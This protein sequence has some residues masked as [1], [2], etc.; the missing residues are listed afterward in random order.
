MRFPCEI[1]QVTFHV[2][3]TCT[4]SHVTFNMWNFTCD[5]SHVNF[6]IWNITWEIS[7]GKF[8]SYM[9][10]TCDISHNMWKV[11]YDL[12]VQF[13]VTYLMWKLTCENFR[14]E[15]SQE[16]FLMVEEVICGISHVNL[17]V[18]L[19]SCEILFFSLSSCSVVACQTFSKITLFWAITERSQHGIVA[20]LKVARNFILDHADTGDI[21]NSP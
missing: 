18:R 1:L 11:L 8:I 3:F 19:F 9:K 20:I 21:D 4:I 16:E 13:C 5:F 14:C 17:S 6:L 15:F 7:H 10:V 2:C 12:F